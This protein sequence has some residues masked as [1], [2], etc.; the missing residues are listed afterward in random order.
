MTDILLNYTR[1]N[2]GANIIGIFLETGTD[3][4]VVQ[5]LVYNHKDIETLG[6]DEALAQWKTNGFLATAASG[7]D[8][9]FIV[10]GQK[11]VEQ[12]GLDELDENA[13]MTKIKNTFVKGGKASKTSRVLLNR[14]IEHLA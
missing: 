6:Y 3:K 10:K 12:I 8:E 14:M 11:K 13:S 9:Y 1:D 5:R 2:T 4:R 7:Y